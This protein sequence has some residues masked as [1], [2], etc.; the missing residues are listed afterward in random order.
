MIRG[1]AVVGTHGIGVA[2]PALVYAARSGALTKLCT[3]DSDELSILTE[4]EWDKYERSEELANAERELYRDAPWAAAG[5][6][7]DEEASGMIV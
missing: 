3:L 4:Q 1:I 2:G 5:E 7:E 6:E